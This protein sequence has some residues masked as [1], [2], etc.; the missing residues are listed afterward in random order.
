MKM[1][2]WM[3]LLAGAALTL[4]SCTTGST[5]ATGNTNSSL[6]T[7]TTSSLLNGTTTSVLTST[8]TSVLGTL[9]STLLGNTTTQTSIVGTWTY[10]APKVAFESENILA[11]IGS[12]VASNKIESML[13]T[14]LTKAGFKAGKTTITFNSDGS[15]SMAR[16]GRTIPGTYT[17]NQKTG[18]M[19]I[20]GALGVTSVTLYV[21]V[22]GSEMYMMFEA[23]KIL[24]M[25]NSM[26]NA[27]T[28]TSTLGS[29]L[30]SYSGLKL[31]W[32]MTRQ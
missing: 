11:Q 14:Q 29:L 22:V 4:N 7:G 28:A 26:A 19:T 8:G 12:S 13:G 3:A 16:S 10:A 20:Q 27:T 30:K 21:S 32:T 17:Y 5:L 23:D 31:G 25:M 6:A 9:M 15:C 1:N 18:Q 2:Y 24:S